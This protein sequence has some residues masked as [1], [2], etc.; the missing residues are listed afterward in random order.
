MQPSAYTPKSPA[1]VL[2]MTFT[3]LAV[4]TAGKLGL[5]I[6]Y[7]IVY[8]LLP[9]LASQLQ[10]SLQTVSA[11]VSVQVGAALL[12]PVSSAVSARFGERTTMVL[13]TLSFLLGTL[14]CLLSSAFGGFLCGYVLI[15]IA[16]AL[17]QP[18]AQSYISART[19]YEARGRAL[20]LL[21]LSWAVAAFVG[22]AP[23][24]LLVQT[25]G[26]ARPAL[27][28][29]LAVAAITAVLLRALLPD[30]PRS[31]V[32][33]TGTSMNWSALRI[34][35]VAAMLLMMGMCMCA[36]DL[37]FVVQGAWLKDA[38]NAN[39]ARLGQLF[40]FMGIVEL[41][42]SLASA[43]FVDRIGKKRAVVAGYGATAALIALLPFSDGN[44]FLF[45]VVFL[46]FDLAFEFAIVSSFPLA[47][48][49][50]PTARSTVM[51][52]L[53]SIIGLGRVVGAT[54]AEPLWAGYGI[55]ANT[56]LAALLT[57]GGVVL[58]VLFVRETERDTRT[59]EPPVIGQHI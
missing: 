18:A 58:C 14:I 45:L 8:P 53:T 43:L 9:F 25:T 10:V 2:P 42:G 12:S 7:R 49:L 33:H 35:R 57:A 6:A 23:L 4:I 54:L 51:A 55:G 5:N 44:W 56:T 20:G 39:E 26:S 11:L 38:F 3:Q 40:A 21:E 27:G 15:G 1:G 46:A 17:Y 34:P 41:I 52:V 50:A 19:P 36:V 30:A 16:T 29:L 32:R 48:G 37:I 31:P 22:V 47:S 24:M 28:V 59:V 13:G